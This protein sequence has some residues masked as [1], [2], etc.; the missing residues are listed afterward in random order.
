MER[1]VSDNIFWPKNT[2]KFI[3]TKKYKKI[4]SDKNDHLSRRHFLRN[5]RPVIWIIITN[6]QQYRW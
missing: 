3:L 6:V 2:Y 1:V 5:C 4:K